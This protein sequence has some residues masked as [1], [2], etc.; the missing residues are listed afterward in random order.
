[1]RNYLNKYMS[2]V[3]GGVHALKRRRS[4]LKAAKGFK[5]GRKSQEKLAKQA[6]IKAWSHM[7]KGR[8][9]KKRNFRA[10]WQT[11]IGA[12]TRLAGIKY[13][14]F[15]DG[16]NKNNIALDRKILADLAEHQPEVFSKI[17]EL[18]QQKQATKAISPK[19]PV[20]ESKKITATV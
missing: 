16:L 15:I 18:S 4:I 9:E 6:L 8:K 17:L 10:L 20:V 12:A 13:N 14:Q 1:M 5:W 7:F 2:R 3:K 19:A 11:K